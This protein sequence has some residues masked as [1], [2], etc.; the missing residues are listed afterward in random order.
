MDASF[1]PSDASAGTGEVCSKT[2]GE[3]EVQTPYVPQ[4]GI[5]SRLMLMKYVERSDGCLSPCP[6]HVIG[7]EVRSLDISPWDLWTEGTGALFHE[8]RY[9]KKTDQSLP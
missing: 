5:P 6:D 1:A 3:E 4:T 8:Y 2:L 9:D 7:D